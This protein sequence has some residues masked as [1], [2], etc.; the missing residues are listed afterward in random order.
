MGV[1]HSC[2]SMESAESQRRDF[3][4]L[5]INRYVCAWNTMCRIAPKGGETASTSIREEGESG[6]TLPG[7]GFGYLVGVRGFYPDGGAPPYCAAAS[8]WK[9]A[10]GG[11]KSVLS[12]IIRQVFFRAS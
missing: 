2:I 3:C 5:K 6:G 10:I 8:R 7:G 1:T 4:P 9:A 12:E 11:R